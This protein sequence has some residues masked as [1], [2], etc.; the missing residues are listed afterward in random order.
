M[1]NPFLIQFTTNSLSGSPLN[2][3]SQAERNRRRVGWTSMHIFFFS[4]VWLVTGCGLLQPSM[5]ILA[6]LEK[7]HFEELKLR[8][9]TVSPPLSLFR[10]LTLGLIFLWIRGGT[11]LCHKFVSTLKMECVQVINIGSPSI[12]QVT[13][14]IP[15]HTTELS[16]ICNSVPIGTPKGYWT[17]SPSV[18]DQPTPLS[19]FIYI[20]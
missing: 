15:G 5:C 20:E 16:P 4:N 6:L 8:H 7:L 12:S 2:S 3:S 11:T 13:G 10:T 18:F 19:H 14:G 1:S 9:M 17:N